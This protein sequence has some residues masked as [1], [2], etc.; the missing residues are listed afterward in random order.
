MEIKRP[1]GFISSFGLIFAVFLSGALSAQQ[2]QGIVIGNVILKL[3][4]FQD[5]NKEIVAPFD[6]KIACWSQDEEG[7]Y[8]DEVFDLKTN[9]KGFY[10]LE[11]VKLKGYF[12]LV[13]IKLPGDQEIVIPSVIK[14]PKSYKGKAKLLPLVFSAVKDDTPY[15]IID[16]GTT[17]F[18]LDKEGNI[19]IKTCFGPYMRKF[20]KQ[21]VEI[22]NE[23]YNF[24]PLLFFNEQLS[25]EYPFLTEYLNDRKLFAKAYMYY[26][27]AKGDISVHEK[28]KLLNEAIR[29]YPKFTDASLLLSETYLQAGKNDAAMV[30][31][32]K[33]NAI[34]PGHYRVLEMLV[35]QLLVQNRIEEATN[36][37][38]QYIGVK[39]D[40]MD[41]YILLADCY[42]RKNEMDN[43]VQM[44]QL[45]V[46][47]A[48]SIQKYIDAA[49][50]FEKQKQNQKAFEYYQTYYRLKPA[51]AWANIYLAFGYMITGDYES[52]RKTIEVYPES[53]VYYYAS[54]KA[55]SLKQYEMAS[56]FAHNALK[57]YNDGTLEIEEEELQQYVDRTLRSAEFEQFWVLY[58]K[59]IQ[60]END[61]GNWQGPPYDLYEK[62]K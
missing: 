47:K 54:L 5:Q 30:L 50:F 49:R 34:V 45:G 48:S 31:L 6:I 33:A 28:E 24:L 55:R 61:F 25:G 8:S 17:W 40:D 18:I 23:E 46:G 57:N 9:E 10:F 62:Q 44:V 19:S 7:E 11:N 35:R 39:E 1:A 27:K 20:S 38:I 36:Y 51:D 37:C 32:D 43:A 13:L 59:K 2:K 53:M 22:E 21:G 41:G 42:V 14:S 16:M 15:N 58:L 4:G 12:R 56:V 3:D 60:A 26:D 29:I 52:A